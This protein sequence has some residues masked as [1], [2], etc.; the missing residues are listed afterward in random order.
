MLQKLAKIDDG[1]LDKLPIIDA[2]PFYI[3][4]NFNKTLDSSKDIENIFT[5]PQ[6]ID[7]RENYDNDNPLSLYNYIV[8]NGKNKEEALK[9]I[10]SR[11]EDSFRNNQKTK[12]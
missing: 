5:I 9:Q 8:I 4:D 2:S 1:L 12:L 6:K 7:R 3:S 11:D 10:K